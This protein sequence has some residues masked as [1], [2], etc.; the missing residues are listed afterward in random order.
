MGDSFATAGFENTL[1]VILLTGFVPV[2]NIINI[3]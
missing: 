3:L 1:K 2:K